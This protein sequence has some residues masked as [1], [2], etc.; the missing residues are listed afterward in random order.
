[1][2]KL[3]QSEQFIMYTEITRHVQAADSVHLLDGN[4]PYITAFL[5]RFET[6][7][8]I[9]ISCGKP[10]TLTVS[11]NGRE[12]SSYPYEYYN[13]ACPFMHLDKIYNNVWAY[14]HPG[15][16]SSMQLSFRL[17]LPNDAVFPIK[18]RLCIFGDNRP[19]MEGRTSSRV[20]AVVAS[21][22]ALGR[23]STVSLLSA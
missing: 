23:G 14:F 4:Y 7:E 15:L 12:I 5:A 22:R 6:T 13:L 10:S 18:L 8:G 21:E 20:N 17:D 2:L 19:D 1:M 16:P 3:K 9:P 11:A